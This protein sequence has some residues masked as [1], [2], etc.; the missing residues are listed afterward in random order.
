[1]TRCSLDVLLDLRRNSLAGQAA[2]QDSP[3]FF[4]MT[5]TGKAFAGKLSA[6]LLATLYITKTTDNYC[7]YIYTHHIYLYTHHTHI[8]IYMHSLLMYVLHCSSVVCISAHLARSAFVCL[9]QATAV[10]FC[11]K[12][13][14]WPFTTAGPPAGSAPSE[15]YGDCVYLV[16]IGCAYLIHVEVIEVFKRASCILCVQGIRLKYVKMKMGWY[17][18]EVLPWLPSVYQWTCNK[19][20]PSHMA[21][22]YVFDLCIN[23]AFAHFAPRS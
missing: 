9:I 17:R 10:A 22:N 20:W 1:M 18:A 2:A 11:Q 5:C 7:I 15:W 14:E 12:Q 4:D 3:V 8:Y 16:V 19:S 21:S 6:E 13:A 23:V